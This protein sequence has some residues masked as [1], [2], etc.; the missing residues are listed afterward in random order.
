MCAHVCIDRQET[1]GVQK[2][3]V[4]AYAYIVSVGPVHE[5]DMGTFFSI[6][7]SL[8]VIIPFAALVFGF[9]TQR[10]MQQTIS[11]AFAGRKQ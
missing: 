4:W 11:D 5:L 3:T 7:L 8:L 6:A 9:P 10:C 1:C 2:P